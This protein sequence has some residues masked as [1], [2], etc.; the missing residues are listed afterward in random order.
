MTPWSGPLDRTGTSPHSLEGSPDAF[1]NINSPARATDQN[2][3]TT[4][5]ANP[6]SSGLKFS[7]SKGQAPVASTLRN[8]TKASNT[9]TLSHD[10]SGSEDEATVSRVTHFENGVSTTPTKK[11]PDTPFIIKPPES[12]NEHWLQRRLKMFRPDLIN[13]PPEGLDLSSVPDKIGASTTG[14][15][16]ITARLEANTPES[17]V[18]ETQMEME[19]SV[20]KSEDEIARDLLLRQ[21]Q[22]PNAVI[23]NQ[24]KIII[25]AQQ[26]PLS[27]SD[28]YAYDMAHLSDA[29]TL[30]TYERVPVE[31][32][33]TGI[34]LGLGWKEGTDL[35]G[36]KVEKF[37][38]PKKR[39]DF[40][41]I[42]AKEAS[43]MK[44]DEKGKKISRKDGLGASWNPLRKIDKVTGEE[45]K[46]ERRTESGRSTPRRRE[47]EGTSTPRDHGSRRES[48]P[49]TPKE[50]RSRYDSPSHRDRHGDRDYHRR[51]YERS[52]SRDRRYDS[53]QAS[54]RQDRS[55]YRDS[56]HNRRDRDYDSDYDRKRRRDGGRNGDSGSSSHKASR[57]TSPD[58]GAWRSSTAGEVKVT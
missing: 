42:G 56:N 53:D 12:Q 10:D 1:S 49:G 55:D 36:E 48:R 58:R 20:P 57:R 41:G 9:L 30:E 38:E 16:Q 31:A 25:P 15:L 21:A 43:F 50:E 33:G 2:E 8:T 7:F 11:E 24:T 40:L 5:P 47:R 14:G 3:R 17:M 6:P 45:I 28:V 54:K 35:R 22:D 19:E 23:S 46:E 37:Q 27:E 39:P 13:A 34:L 18:E 52:D 32:F 26:T 44:L 51:D 4:S 29:P